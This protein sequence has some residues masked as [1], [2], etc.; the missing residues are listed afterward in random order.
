MGN[1]IY[2][3]LSS[4]SQSSK[5][6]HEAGN[7]KWIAISVRA[8]F[9]WTLPV[10]VGNGN[11]SCIWPQSICYRKVRGC[12]ME[13][14]LTF[15]V[16]RVMRC[17]DQVGGCASTCWVLSG[18]LWTLSQVKGNDLLLGKVVAG[19]GNFTFLLFALCLWMIYSPTCVHGIAKEKHMAC[20]SVAQL[21]MRE[22][23]LFLGSTWTRAVRATELSLL[24][25][26]G[27]TV[28]PS[29]SHLTSSS[30]MSFLC[31]GW[32]TVQASAELLYLSPG[33]LN[34]PVILKKARTALLHVSWW[35]SL[36]LD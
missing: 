31:K 33:N 19:D 12:R 8:S 28:W 4:L 16:S 11:K 21:L 23:W 22:V 20:W 24:L 1:L 32:K 9:S 27:V 15:C 7:T 3:W 18:P 35:H 25:C 13:V 6:H 2:V 36:V 17:L 14:I 10:I 30:L 29:S 34:V 5:L 26:W